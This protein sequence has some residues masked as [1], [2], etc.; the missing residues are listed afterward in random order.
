M[1]KASLWLIGLSVLFAIL[2]LISMF[3]AGGIASMFGCT[4]DESGTS[5]C[6]TPLGDLG[7]TLSLMGIVGWLVFFT[8]PIGFLGLLLGV[9]L[10]IVAIV[11]A[12][13]KAR[14]LPPQG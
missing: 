4:I 10:L 5:V 11:R 9:L 13:L 12:K 2:P 8:V 14:S 1:K 6:M 3:I 7:G